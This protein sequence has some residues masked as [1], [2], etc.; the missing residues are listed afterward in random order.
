MTST[1]Q[2]AII[3]A[4]I[5]ATNA[6]DTDTYLE[7]FTDD[8]VLDDPSVGEKFV[9]KDGIAEY[10]RSYFIGYN[11]TTRLV[12]AEAAGDQLHVVVD[13]TGD[14]PGGQTGGI[15]DITFTGDKILLIQANLT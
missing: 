11:T 5:A 14:F 3:S 8:A 2:E 7:F 12:R 6:H 10:Y 15:F 9:G 4:W 13:F 1:D